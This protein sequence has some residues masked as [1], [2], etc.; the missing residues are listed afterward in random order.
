M[1]SCRESASLLLRANDVQLSMV[2]KLQ[3]RLHLAMCGACTNFSKQVKVMNSAMG[4]WRA[5]RNEDE[6]ADH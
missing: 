5:Y 2:Q 4:P 6:H 1:L 3:V